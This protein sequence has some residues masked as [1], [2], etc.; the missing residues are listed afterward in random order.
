V[1]SGA[2]DLDM[3]HMPLFFKPPAFVPVLV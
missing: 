3:A 2:D 1:Q